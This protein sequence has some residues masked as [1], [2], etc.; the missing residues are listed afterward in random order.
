M[1]E[2]IIM[3]EECWRN[4]QFSVARFYGGI[5]FNKKNYSIVNKDGITLR[6]LSDP[7]SPHYVTEGMAIPPGEPA[8]LILDTW[9]PVYKELGRKKTFGIVESGKTPGEALL[10]VKEVKKLKKDGKAK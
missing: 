6:E 2:P 8:D 9:I 10:M 3:A 4:S 1:K 5:N 7:S